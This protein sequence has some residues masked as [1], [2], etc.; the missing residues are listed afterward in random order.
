MIQSNVCTN[1]NKVKEIVL[2]ICKQIR[3]AMDKEMRIFCSF[4]LTELEKIDDDIVVQMMQKEE[5][6]MNQ[7]F[8]QIGSVDDQKMQN[9]Q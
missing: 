1:K 8:S 7:R 3:M 5:F 2:K 6:S 9:R 4:L